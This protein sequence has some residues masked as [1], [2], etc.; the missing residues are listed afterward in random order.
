MPIP[1]PKDLLKAYRQGFN[2]TELL[3]ET[4]GRTQ[5][6]E[7]I[8]EVAY[9]LQAG[10][11][12]AAMENPEIARHKGEYTAAIAREILGLTTP[13]S[14]LEAGVG[15]ATTLSGVLGALAMD[16][17][18]VYG[19]DISWSRLAVA[20]QWL[21]Q[22]ALSQV[23]LCTG[24]LLRIP[25]ADNSIDVVYTSHTIEPNAGQEQPILRELYRVTRKWL[26]LLEPG[27][28]LAGDE[29]RRR[30]EH[31]GYCRGLAE[32]CRALGYDVVRHELFPLTANPLNPT[33]ITVISKDEPRE[34]PTHVLACPR[35]KTPLQ[36]LG[37]MLYSPE[38]LAVYPVLCG[39]PC[40]RPE[41]AILANL[42]PDFFQG[43]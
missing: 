6:S 37:G 3:H 33:A 19:F 27:Y 8:I 41:S 14:L 11:Y 18:Q 28:E 43:L 21:T 30:M 39:I 42:Y 31:F 38:A 9:D 25:F 23:R 32:T 29:A 35:F 36:E 17:S 16:P 7:E 10:N 26:L 24:S 4:Q 34:R 1:T 20:R 13:T 12:I 2:I 22:K 15:E 40:L 5:N